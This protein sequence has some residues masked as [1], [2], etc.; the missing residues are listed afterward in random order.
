MEL[1]AVK[2][3]V[4]CL[5]TLPISSFNRHK[6]MRD[7]RATRC[8]KCINTNRNNSNRGLYK[9]RQKMKAPYKYK[10]R[11]MIDNRIQKGTLLRL[12][13]VICGELKT[14]AHHSDY[15]K[16][17]DVMWLCE[18]HHC[19]WHRVFIASEGAE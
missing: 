3:C 5:E 11:R 17:L 19:A 8:K 2:Q 9:H 15:S 16:P 1:E 18:P 10:A 7:G 4:F 12:P 13:C 6:I 14:H